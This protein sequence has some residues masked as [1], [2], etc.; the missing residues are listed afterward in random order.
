[1]ILLWQTVDLGSTFSA[2]VRVD[3]DSWLPSP[4]TIGCPGRKPVPAG[5]ED[6][7]CVKAGR[8]IIPARLCKRALKHTFLN[9][10]VSA[11]LLALSGTSRL[12]FSLLL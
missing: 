5:S 3:Q 10:F 11:F 7:A 4:N 8:E 6:L 1:M 12:K 2:Q 9:S